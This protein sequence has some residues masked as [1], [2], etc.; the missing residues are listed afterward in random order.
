MKILIQWTKANPEDWTEISSADWM[1]VIA[2]RAKAV[3]IGGEVIDNDP[4]W[5]YAINVQ[6]MVSGS[7]DHYHIED[8][9]V[10][11]CRVTMWVDDLEDRGIGERW[12]R[13]WTFPPLNTIASTAS[14]INTAIIQEKFFDADFSRFIPPI[15]GV[16]HGIWV[17][18]EQDVAHE[19]ARGLR[20]WREWA[21][22][23]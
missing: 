11:G 23:D 8:L 6:G 17:S 19:Q 20:G 4:G 21:N 7:A 14:G 10:R 22:G 15:E 3:P 9:G 18:D 16:V 13:I 1:T 12:A 5:I 2:T